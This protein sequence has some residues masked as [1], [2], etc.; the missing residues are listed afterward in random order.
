MT[1]NPD[2]LEDP[3]QQSLTPRA[4]AAH[5]IKPKRR[6][7]VI[8]YP[9]WRPIFVISCVIAVSVDPLFFYLPVID[10]KNKC[11]G[12]DKTLKVVALVLRSLT[13]VTLIVNI[14]Y[15][16]CKAIKAA[17]KS[18]DEQKKKK[19]AQTRGK[20]DKKAGGKSVCEWNEIV[21]FAKALAQKLSWRSI[22]I[23]FFAVLPIPQV[24]I[25]AAASKMRSSKYIDKK[26]TLNF[27]LLAQYLPRVYRMHHSSI[28]LRRKTGIWTKGAFNFFLYILASHVLGAFWYFFSIQRETSCWHRAC[29]KH[30][31]TR[32][33]YYCDE[34]TA[35]RNMT[36][37]NS[38]D[39][40]CLVDVPENATAPFDFGIFLDSLK[41]GNAGSIDFR[42]KFLYS[43]WWGLRNLSNFG[44]NLETSTYVWEN[45]FAILISVIGLLLFLYLIGKV[46]TFISMRTQKSEERDKKLK[47]KKLGIQVWMNKHGFTD[48]MKLEMKEHVKRNWED[49]KDADMENLFSILPGKT[50]KVLKEHICME[51]LKNVPKLANMDVKVLKMICEYLIPVSYRDHSFIFRTE[52]PMDRMLFITKGFVLT[53]P[54][55]DSNPSVIEKRSLKSGGFYGDEE[56]LTWVA[57]KENP[58]LSDL[59]T[60]KENVK[61]HSK[62]DCFVLLAKDLRTVVSRSRVYWDLN[63]SEK[64]EEVAKA[65]ILP[66]LRLRL[67]HQRA[68]A[69]NG[70]SSNHIVIET[71]T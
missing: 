52:E 53:S 25:V 34:D 47:M 49:I 67:D 17:M 60:L 30:S 68:G 20:K 40:F 19:E 37:I 62:V 55:S 9:C 4:S 41:T 42:K 48:Q 26:K 39:E 3:T 46:H 12:M 18:R 63:N 21:P 11:L 2:N 29:I 22:I 13:D 32:C 31:N 50:R 57:S 6:I 16:F 58:C 8:L 5:P 36:F 24:L 35:S 14:I 28:E 69:Q 70:N 23:D 54:T 71:S 10:E 38:L 64:K 44:T 43:F 45:C 27:F 7:P 61:C 1:S 66:F 59:P 33:N 65:A 56:L 51:M 15:Q